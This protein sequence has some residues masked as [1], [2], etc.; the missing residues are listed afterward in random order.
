MLGTRR[1]LTRAT[2]ARS[3]GAALRSIT[4]QHPE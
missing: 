1:I 4:G 2:E 3:T